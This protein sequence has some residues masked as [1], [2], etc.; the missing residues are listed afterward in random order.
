MKTNAKRTPVTDD[1]VEAL[2]QGAIDTHIHASPDLVPRKM[3]DIN[4]SYYNYTMW[5]R[6]L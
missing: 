3:S 1:I 4:S 2:L 6:D 5:R